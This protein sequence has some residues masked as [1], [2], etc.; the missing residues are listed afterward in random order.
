MPRRAIPADRPELPL[1]KQLY[2]RVREAILAGQLPPG[3]RLPSTRTLASELGVSRGTTALA[4]D[5]LLLEGYLESQVGRGTRV[6]SE[7]P[8]KPSAELSA[9]MRE[10]RAD[11]S[12]ISSLHIADRVRTLRQGPNPRRT[13]GPGGGGL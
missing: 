7:F 13:R 9:G 5:H 1:D 11:P 12:Q 2:E 8:A 10:S 4:Y 3:T 6:S